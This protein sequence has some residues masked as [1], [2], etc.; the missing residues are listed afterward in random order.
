MKS[1]TYPLPMPGDLAAQVKKAAKETGLSKADV[2]RQSIRIGIPQ[3]VGRLSKKS[4]L[5]NVEPLPDE[6]LDRLYKE[7]DDD[8][9][10]DGVK[11][12]MAAQPL[13]PE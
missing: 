11:K 13:G 6:V 9:D 1:E 5:T 2:M 8:A 10:L 7:R 4:P 3:L 12:L